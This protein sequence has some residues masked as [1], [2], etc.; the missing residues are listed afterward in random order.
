MLDAELLRETELLRRS[1]MQHDPAKL[2]NYLVADVEDPRIN[3]KSILSRHFIL[4]QLAGGRF[5]SL[6]EQELRFALVMNWLL[7]L[8]KSSATPDDLQSILLGLRRG[9]D[10]AEGIQIPGFASRT[11]R[12]LAEANELCKIPDYFD[13]AFSAGEKADSV[14]AI[15]Q[16]VWN[17]ILQTQSFQRISL[18]EPACGSANDYRFLGSFG[19]MRF[20]DYLGFD[21]CEKNI[22]NARE[23]F[24]QARF[25]VGNI[26]APD[27][28]DNAFNCA[29]VHDLF[30]HLSVPAMERAV[31]E[32]CRITSQAICVGFFSMHEGSHHVVRRVDD[33]HWNTLGASSIKELF[34]RHGFS[35]Q[36]IHIDTFLQSCFHFD[37]THNKDAYTLLA[38]K[39]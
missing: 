14:R 17:G 25:E 20:L 30:E 36:L 33:Y 6:R 29:I 24:P 21:L 35:V 4:E 5:A 27:F 26:L 37:Q 28:P 16:H 23:M 8:S 12:S 22:T 34:V 15:F 3:I 19:L 2:R 32:L 13:L 11:F 10:N 1:W 31:H 18:V 39:Q 9:A 38:R 7:G